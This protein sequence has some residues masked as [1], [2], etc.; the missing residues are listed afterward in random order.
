MSD[1][2]FGVSPVNYPDPDPFKKRNRSLPKG[3]FISHISQTAVAVIISAT[4]MK[5][6]LPWFTSETLTNLKGRKSNKQST[7]NL[8]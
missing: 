2:R 8:V 5:S 3:V 6:Y 4:M 1:C 7:N